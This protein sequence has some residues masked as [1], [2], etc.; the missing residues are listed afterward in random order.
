MKHKYNILLAIIV[1]AMTNLVSLKSQQ[2]AYLKIEL[3]SPAKDTISNLH[4]GGFIEFIRDFVNGPFGFWSQEF[5]N[6]GFDYT[7]TSNN[8]LKDWKKYGESE[9]NVISRIA[10]GYNENG[11]NLVRIENGLNDFAGAYQ[12]V[13]VDDTVSLELYFYCRGK[14]ESGNIEIR[15]YDDD[16]DNLLYSHKFDSP[17]DEWYKYTT[18]IPPISGQNKV[19]LVIGLNGTGSIDLDESSCMPT[20]NVLGVR[21][22]YYD[23]LKDWDMGILRYPGGSFADT[24]ASFWHYGVGDIDKRQSPNIDPPPL[25]LS[26]RFD[27]GTIEFLNFCK[28]INTVPHITANYDNGWPE[29]A[30]GWVE[31]CNGDINTQFGKLR[32]EHGYAEPFNVK[33]WEVGNEQWFR[34]QEYAYEY[35]DF[36]R[37]MLK[38]DNKIKLILAADVWHGEDYFK[39]LMDTIK[40]DA[41][42]YGYHPAQS[43]YTKEEHTDME[44]YFSI[45]GGWTHFELYFRTVYGWLEDANLLPHVQAASTEWFMSYGKPQDWYLDTNWRSLTLEQGLWDANTQISHVKNPKMLKFAERTFAISFFKTGEHPITKRRVIWGNVG[46]QAIKLLSNT[47]GSKI[48]PVNVDVEKYYTREIMGILPIYGAPWLNTLASSKGDTLYLAVV[49]AHPFESVNTELDLNE[50]FLGQTGTI[51]EISSNHHH[52]VNDIINPLNIVPKISKKTISRYYEFPKNS[53]T[54]IAIPNFTKASK[55]DTNPQAII[56]PNPFSDNFSFDPGEEF[57][58]NFDLKVFDLQGREIIVLRNQSGDLNI[59]CSHLSQGVYTLSVSNQTKNK[60][61]RIVKIK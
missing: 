24:Y 22:E 4:F 9:S 19:A 33:Y 31:Y 42:Y 2:E 7:D 16:F 17:S 60:A 58:G 23:L 11:R 43:G 26:Q 20:N 12:K 46:Y 28:L 27:F 40:T 25:R 30:G 35:F 50:K 57:L 61:F 18:I 14:V 47:T 48:Y 13:Y 45:V 59:D 44:L 49:N 41:D 52:D 39:T 5:L 55:I 32:M 54:V 36:R 56:Y 1:I 29:L 8:W 53:I 15:V 3:D 6:R 38:S 10:G 21:R 34:P 37:E 51:Y